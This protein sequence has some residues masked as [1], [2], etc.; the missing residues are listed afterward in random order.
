MWKKRFAGK[1]WLLGI[2]IL[3]SSSCASLESSSGYRMTMPILDVSPREAPC[4]ARD[5]T[6][7]IVHEHCTTLLTRDYKRI[8]VEL[9]AACIAFGGTDEECRAN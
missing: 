2:S 9:V 1:L 5:G 7:Q 6:G 4:Q 8:V 3:L